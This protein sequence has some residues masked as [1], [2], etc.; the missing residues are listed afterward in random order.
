VFFLGIGGVAQAVIGIPD[1]VPGSTLLFPFFKVNPN[2]TATDTQD[3]LLVVTNTAGATTSAQSA[4][5]PNIVVHFTIWSVASRHIYDFSVFLTPHDVFS[6]S[7]YDL[8]VGGT[9]CAN[10]SF[11]VAAAPTGV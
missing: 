10:G 2:R 4:K 9:G 7:L 5:N 1:D 3:T 11:T 6:C 8:I